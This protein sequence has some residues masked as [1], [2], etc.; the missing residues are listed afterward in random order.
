MM[1]AVCL[2]FV[3]IETGWLKAKPIVA[4]GQ[5]PRYSRSHLLEAVGL[6]DS[7]YSTRLLV[8]P[9]LMSTDSLE[10]PSVSGEQFP[11]QHLKRMT[12][13]CTICV[14]SGHTSLPCVHRSTPPGYTSPMATINGF[15]RIDVG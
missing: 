5:R 15:G 12:T 1:A 3:S 2:G 8:D 6:V 7:R 14:T 4:Y 9:S 11:K 13:R 10:I